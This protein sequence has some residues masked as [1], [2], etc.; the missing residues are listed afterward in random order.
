MCHSGVR[1][2]R[3]FSILYRIELTVTS[4][5]QGVSDA[6][7]LAFSILYRIELTVTDRVVENGLGGELAF[8]ILY[9]IEL[10]VTRT[11]TAPAAPTIPFQYPLSDRTHCN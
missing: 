7:I 5:A 11:T 3:T 9:R 8:S 1:A 10:T 6:Y 2:R 4:Y